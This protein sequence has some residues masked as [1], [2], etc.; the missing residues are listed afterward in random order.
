M[1]ERIG[2]RGEPCGVPSGTVKGSM[3]VESRHM[4][5]VRLVRNEKTH[6]TKF[7]GKP[8]LLKISRALL[9]SM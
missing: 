6:F 8:F 1:A 7:G 5:A 2:D 9:A 4:E 3:S